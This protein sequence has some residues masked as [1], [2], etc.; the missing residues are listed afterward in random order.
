MDRLGDVTARVVILEDEGAI[1]DLVDAW[2]TRRRPD[3]RPSGEADQEGSAADP[4]SVI[5]LSRRGSQGR[6][7][8]EPLSRTVGGD[9]IYQA[10]MEWVDARL[11]A[12]RDGENHTPHICVG[13]LDIDTAR[14]DV[15]FDGAEVHLTPTEFRLLQYLAEHPDRVAGHKELLETVWGPGYEADV[16]LLQ[17]TMRSLRARLALVTAT[18][19]IETVYGAG[20]RMARPAADDA[21]PQAPPALPTDESPGK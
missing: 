13:P 3:L 19:V 18:Q 21:E 5:I 11:S 14:R 10:L 16:H 12:G 8:G 20:Y 1:A 4:P 17:V 2:L 9:P 6:I 7:D 15:R